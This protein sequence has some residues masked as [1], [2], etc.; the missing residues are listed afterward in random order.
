MKTREGSHVEVVVPA[1][2]RLAL[3]V[4][5]SGDI[6]S[7]GLS[8]SSPAAWAEELAGLLGHSQWVTREVTCADAAVLVWSAQGS[9][10][11]VNV[12]VMVMLAG[13]G[14]HA[15]LARGP[16]LMTGPAGPGGIPGPVSAEVA[17]SLVFG[18]DPVV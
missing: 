5:V 11:P 9:L 1:E 13:L 2:G 14:E 8:A 12:R 18:Y 16:V 3:L 7:V 6:R 17:H 4:D 15:W 10:P